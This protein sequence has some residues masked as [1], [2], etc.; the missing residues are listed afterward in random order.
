MTDEFVAMKTSATKPYIAFFPRFSRMGA[1]SRYRCFQFL[2]WLR[3]SGISFSVFPLFGDGYLQ[4]RYRGEGWPVALMF[5][6]YITRIRALKQLPRNI[7]LWI[8]KELFPWLP[9]AF[10]EIFL[11]ERR[12][13]MDMDDCVFDVYRRYPIL[14]DKFAKLA[15]RAFEI[16]VGNRELADDAG[17][18]S[19]GQVHIF[20]TVLSTG[21]YQ[22]KQI[23]S[24]ADHLLPVTERQECGMQGV[25]KG[26]KPLILGWIGSPL[27]QCHL[28]QFFPVLE[29]LTKAAGIPVEL[30]CMGTGS[31]FPG[32]LPQKHFAWSSEAEKK[33]CSQVDVGIMPLGV[34]DLS[35]GKCGFK[36]LQFMAAGVPVVASDSRANRDILEDGSRGFLAKSPEDWQNALRTLCLSSDARRI[37]GNAGKERVLHAYSLNSW[38]PRWCNAVMHVINAG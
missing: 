9:Y 23:V 5:R 8:E 6:A 27:S 31:Q 3:D 26:T 4:R 35:R 21:E 37:F 15:H 13:I 29:R 33:F 2:P 7:P 38:A 17:R 14:R 28:E 36:L 32:A 16:H 12:Y 10:E 1:S 11:R 19:S 25:L 24:G 30:H 20:P 22:Q 34:H 18:Y